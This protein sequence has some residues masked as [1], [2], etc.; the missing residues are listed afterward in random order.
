MPLVSKF[1]RPNPTGCL[2]LGDSRLGYAQGITNSSSLFET[3]L[4]AS[5]ALG[6]LI[7]DATNGALSFSESYLFAIPGETSLGMLDK[8]S[9]TGIA[10]TGNP[11]YAK[12]SQSADNNLN[13]YSSGTYSVLTHPANVALMFISVNDQTIGSYYT[14]PLI[15]MQ[16][17]AAALDL[18]KPKTVYLMNEFP[19]NTQMVWWEAQTVTLLACQSTNTV[20]FIDGE[21][22]GVVGLLNKT[23]GA[24]YT[25][26]TSLTA[27][28][29][30]TVTAGGAYA[31]YVGDTIS[32]ALLTYSW[33]GGYGTT[34][35]QITMHNWLQSNLP[36]FI[37]PVS[38]V[39]YNISGALFNRPHVFS[40][41]SWGAVLD[42]VYTA[43]PSCIPGGSMDALHLTPYTNKLISQAVA[44]TH[45]RAYPAGAPDLSGLVKSGYLD[46]SQHICGAPNNIRIATG[47]FATKTWTRTLPSTMVPV[48]PGTLAVWTGQVIGFDDGAG[49]LVGT[50]VGTSTIN[51]AT[52]VITF[53]VTGTAPGSVGIYAQTDPTNVMENGLFAVSNSAVVSANGT[54]ASGNQQWPWTSFTSGFSPCTSVNSHV[55]SISPVYDDG[56]YPGLKVVLSNGGPCGGNPTVSISGPNITQGAAPAGAFGWA[57]GDTLAAVCRV[58]ILPGPDGRLYGL[59]AISIGFQVTSTAQAITKPGQGSTVTTLI[60]AGGTGAPGYPINDLILTNGSFSYTQVSP[61]LCTLGLATT[62][63]LIPQLVIYQ[64]HNTSNPTPISA[65]IIFSRYAIRKILGAQGQ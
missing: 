40:V 48:T 23:T 5:E 45:K 47:D 46:G 56:G 10:T 65:T 33:R 17:I 50:G 20:G 4:R 38:N 18:L 12:T 43:S 15:S 24:V 44:A 28:G 29:Q 37:D 55:A 2:M 32:T 53:V 26:V 16:T 39:R 6:S 49:H 13:T 57:V 63:V 8:M 41:D 51:Y 30:Y 34:S 3:Q 22:F 62:S 21:S 19:R 58:Q 7:A 36:T 60:S 61:S 1:A 64:D 27:V 11:A 54:G 35:T 42:P 25:K 9:L 31:F 59:E 52:G 14:S